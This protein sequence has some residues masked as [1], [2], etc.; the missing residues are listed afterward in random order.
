MLAVRG[1]HVQLV[2]RH[3]AVA[4]NLHGWQLPFTMRRFEDL[5]VEI[6]LHTY[7][8]RIGDHSVTLYDVHSDRERTVDPVSAVVMVTGRTART[9]LRDDLGAAIETH[10]IGDAWFPRDM[11][12][13]TRDGH[14]VA[15]DL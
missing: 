15:W 10:L 11:T 6:V 14:R 13:A 2:S 8:R 1:A 3:P 4:H 7:V 5:G 9:G 12:A